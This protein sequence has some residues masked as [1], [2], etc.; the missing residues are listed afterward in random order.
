MTELAAVADKVVEAHN[1][2][3]TI[4]KVSL[5]PRPMPSTTSDALAGELQALRLEVKELRTKVR[6]LKAR[7]RDRA[8]SVG[9]SRSRSRP[10]LR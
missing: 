5:P 9:S 2:R 8:R 10:R 3:P 6:D 4:A 7:P 1:L